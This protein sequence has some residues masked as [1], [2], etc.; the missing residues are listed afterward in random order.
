MS[1]KDRKLFGEC[2]D[3][4]RRQVVGGLLASLGVLL[5]GCRGSCRGGGYTRRTESG[6]QGLSTKNEVEAIIKGLTDDLTW[7]NSWKNELVALIQAGHRYLTGEVEKGRPF[8]FTLVGNGVTLTVE[9][10][11]KSFPEGAKAGSLQRFQLQSVKRELQGKLILAADFSRVP[12]FQEDNF[13]SQQREA[14]EAI[15]ESVGKELVVNNA[16]F[17][18][19][20]SLFFLR[21]LEKLRFWWQKEGNRA[22]EKRWQE[23]EA[24]LRGNEPFSFEEDQFLP[25][26]LSRSQL[27]LSLVTNKLKPGVLI[28][29][30][31]NSTA[32]PAMIIFGPDD[33]LIR[34]EGF[35]NVLFLL[36]FG[37]MLSKGEISSLNF[38]Q[39][40]QTLSQKRFIS[41]TPSFQTVAQN[42]TEKNSYRQTEL[43]RNL[44]N[45]WLGIEPPPDE[46]FLIFELLGPGQI[47]PKKFSPAQA[48]PLSFSC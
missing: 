4:R 2:A 43:V 7:P 17:I 39:V 3:P 31:D 27:F 22:F 16:T 28:P 23:V 48:R 41:T 45:N 29:S 20:Y 24:I 46:T 35:S 14:V 13:T 6:V 9:L 8:D 42:M 38:N 15:A 47:L 37:K 40:V 34:R 5:T 36:L 32:P 12:V 1:S 19:F 21:L 11:V 30:L 26:F 25:R 18:L 44:V 10:V 33:L